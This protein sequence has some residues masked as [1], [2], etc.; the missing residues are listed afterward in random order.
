MDIT[1]VIRG[2]G[3]LSNTPR[4]VLDLRSLRL[5]GARMGACER[6]CR[7]RP[8]ESSRSATA[9]RRSLRFAISATRR[10]LSTI[11]WRC[12]A[13][14]RPT[15]ANTCRSPNRNRSLTLRAAASLRRCSTSSISPKRQRSISR[16]LRS[17]S[18]RLTCFPNQKL[19]WLS[20]QHIRA[21]PDDDFIA[22]ILP[23]VAATGVV[24]AEE[25]NADN[26]RLKRHFA[27]A[28]GVSRYARARLSSTSPTSTC[29]LHPRARNYVTSEYFRRRKFF[30]AGRSNA[31]SNRADGR[32]DRHS[33]TGCRERGD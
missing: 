23:F 10:A 11:T 14:H 12:S 29:R 2:V 1:H 24:P 28:Q 30:V 16:R 3:H 26:E 19:N 13:G 8:Q 20:N 5:E 22:E 27:V 15:A 6:D 32:S 33:R 31:A 18:S 21:T 7:F 17:P 4:Q 9:Q 25:C